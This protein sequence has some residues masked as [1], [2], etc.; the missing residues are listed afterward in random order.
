MGKAGFKYAWVLDKHKAERERGI[1]IEGSIW[2]F[3]ASRYYCTIVDLPGHRD[4]TKNAI[5]G[6]SQ[7][8]IAMLVV[9][10]TKEEKVKGKCIN[11]CMIIFLLFLA[12]GRKIN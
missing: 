12:A 6:L 7:A 2:R 10:A 11:C 5:K 4:F 3:P 9:D 8:D 1:T